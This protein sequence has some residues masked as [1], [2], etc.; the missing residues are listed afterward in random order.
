MTFLA[1]D[2]RYDVGLALPGMGIP[3]GFTRTVPIPPI[4]GRPVC[5]QAVNVLAGSDTWL[6]CR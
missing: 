6:G 3:H 1:D 4:A 5:V 2:V